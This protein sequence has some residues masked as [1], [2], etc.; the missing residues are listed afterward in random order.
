[1]DVGMGIYMYI[2]IYLYVYICVCVCICI[3]VCIHDSKSRVLKQESLVSFLAVNN[4][5]IGF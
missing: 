4:Y 2:C 1:M 3:C 5:N